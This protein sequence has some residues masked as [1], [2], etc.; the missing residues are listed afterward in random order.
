M[1]GKRAGELANGAEN[2][3]WKEQKMFKI[4]KVKPL[5]KY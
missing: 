4:L 5:N 3:R 1:N 2:V